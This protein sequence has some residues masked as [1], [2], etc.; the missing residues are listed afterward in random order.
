MAPNKFGRQVTF[1][2]FAEVHVIRDNDS[3]SS[4]SGSESAGSTGSCV[5][6]NVDDYYSKPV[7]LNQ[8]LLKKPGV[9]NKK[10][11]TREIDLN[12]STVAH[13]GHCEPWKESEEPV[14]KVDERDLKNYIE[15]VSKNPSSLR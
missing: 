15:S 7:K 5:A 9:V 11:K 10:K 2:P 12:E 1:K 4:G 14:D 3:E 13:V 6:Y 8:V